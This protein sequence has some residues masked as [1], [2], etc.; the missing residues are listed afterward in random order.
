MLK[1]LH[2]TMIQY[3]GLL[4]HPTEWLWSPHPLSQLWHFIPYWD[5]FSVLTALQYKWAKA[6]LLCL[7]S[8]ESLKNK[9][10]HIRW[11]LHVLSLRFFTI[12]NSFLRAQEF[13]LKTTPPPG[14]WSL[15]FSSSLLPK[16]FLLNIMSQ[17]YISLLLSGLMVGQ[18][19]V[20]CQS[21]FVVLWQCLNRWQYSSGQWIPS[22]V[23]I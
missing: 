22:H 18:R 4:S 6:L 19:S 7:V 2:I 21:L 5:F 10:A 14:Y 8:L 16:N 9:P 17:L 15:L 13:F 12:W 23:D 20:P 1:I 3:F 11:T